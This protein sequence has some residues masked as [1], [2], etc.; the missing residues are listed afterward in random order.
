MLRKNARTTVPEESAEPP[1]KK[2]TH[3][4]LME[5][6]LDLILDYLHRAERRDRW[7]TVGG[8]IRNFILLI[9]FFAFLG[10]LWFVYAYG[11]DLLNSV[12]NRAAQQSAQYTKGSFEKTFQGL[13]EY[14]GGQ[15]GSSSSARN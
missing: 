15:Q 8:A 3:E 9:P 12:A 4:E 10:S 5:G 2:M 13:V 7:R 1:R 6:R 11:E 14:F